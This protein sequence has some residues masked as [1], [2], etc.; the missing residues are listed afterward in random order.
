MMS[1]EWQVSGLP[2]MQVIQAR[3]S[4]FRSEVSYGRDN[5]LG[6]VSAAGQTRTILVTGTFWSNSI[7]SAGLQGIF[8]RGLRGAGPVH[9]IWRAIME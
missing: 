2:F 7:R 1:N 5:H 8:F 9:S 3:W 6:K 4:C